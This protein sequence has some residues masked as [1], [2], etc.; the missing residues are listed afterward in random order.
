[1]LSCGE[2]SS[3]V[4]GV[5]S[6]H[7]NVESRNEIIRRSSEEAL[8]R[9]LNFASHLGLP[10]VMIELKGP[11]NANL[12][13]L[14]YCFMLKATAAQI[15]IRVPINKPKRSETDPWEWW[16]TLRGTSNTEKRLNLALGTVLLFI[17]HNIAKGNIPYLII[18]PEKKS[19][20]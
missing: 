20:K 6:R 8:N 17:W 7:L 3:L 15:W 9:E 18:Q 13:I 12:S 11:N 1:M 14:L 5:I 10:A 19:R 4:V 2:W 16:N